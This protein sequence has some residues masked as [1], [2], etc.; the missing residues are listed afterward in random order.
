[1]TQ[2]KD[3]LVA[4]F[5]EFT[6]MQPGLH[7][8]RIHEFG[9]LENGCK[10]TGEIYNPF[11]SP[12]GHSHNDI[13]TRR[14]GDIEHIQARFDTNAEYRCRDSLTTMWGVNSILGRSLVIYEREDDFDQ[15]EHEATADKEERKREGKGE[16]VACCVIGLAK[17]EKDGVDA[18][19]NVGKTAATKK[20]QPL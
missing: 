17:Q 8:L 3:D 10:S 19:I 6:G 5:G 12:H 14:V 15:T 18:I 20:A 4:Y 7:A 9:D 16:A 1:M 13:N 2:D 11:G